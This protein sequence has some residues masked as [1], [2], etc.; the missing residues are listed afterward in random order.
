M[1]DLKKMPKCMSNFL[2]S[3]L[4]QSEED[5]TLGILRCTCDPSAKS[6]EFYGPRGKKEASEAHDPEY[7]G[8][9]EL[10][11]EEKLADKASQ[12]ALWAVS[13]KVTGIKFTI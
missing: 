1:D 10:K 7:K 2:F 8:M 13:E 6:R 5:A 11:A 4:M 9:A 12:D 3:K